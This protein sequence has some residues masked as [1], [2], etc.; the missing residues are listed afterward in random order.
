MQPSPDT[1][2]TSSGPRSEP[3]IQ[4]LARGVSLRASSERQKERK[5]ATERNNIVTEKCER[6]I[7]EIEGRKRRERR[8]REKRGGGT[9]E[10]K[11]V[12]SRVSAEANK[13]LRFNVGA[14]VLCS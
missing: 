3:V 1:Q 14:V 7:Q 11:L 9:E 4:H 13:S 8:G 10:P 2:L 6:E 5:T 12:N